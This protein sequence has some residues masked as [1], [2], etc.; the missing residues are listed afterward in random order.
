MYVVPKE[1]YQAAARLRHSEDFQRVVETLRAR[2]HEQD[3]ANRSTQ[4]ETLYRGQG[5]SQCLAWLVEHIEDAPSVI[6]RS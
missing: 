1:F 2:L 6:H 3:V 5:W 4:G